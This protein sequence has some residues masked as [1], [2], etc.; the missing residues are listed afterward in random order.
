MKTKTGLQVAAGAAAGV[1]V[2]AG[3][4]AIRAAGAN[5][6]HA[7]HNG[8]RRAYAHSITIYRT[9]ADVYAFWRELS[10]LASAIERVRQVQPLDD[11]RSRWVVD[12]PGNTEIVFTADIVADEPGEL[13][14]WRSEDSP[15]PHA[16]R[17]ELSEAP[18]AR[19]T[20]VRV[21][22]TLEPPA[23]GLGMAMARLTGDSPDQLVRTGLRRIK[24]VLECGEVIRVDG[25]PSG[26]GPLSERITE[27]VDHRLATG[28]R[29]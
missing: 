3:V 22:L 24:Q 10:T 21:V 11:T 15:V 17:V 29:A 1:A 27:L 18:G 26:R 14:A 7:A 2:V 25:Q 5:G 19:G 4:R 12:G 23:G 28:G 20:E 8:K 9:P 16:G 13:I 6:A